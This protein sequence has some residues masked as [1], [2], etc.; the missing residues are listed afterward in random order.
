M[1]G[2]GSSTLLCT[3]DGVAVVVLSTPWDQ[4]DR[5]DMRRSPRAAISP[6]HACHSVSFGTWKKC[7]DDNA[8][9]HPH[10]SRL[11]SLK[12]QKWLDLGGPGPDLLTPDSLAS[13]CAEF[14][15]VVSEQQCTRT[16]P[17]RESFSQ[18][19]RKSHL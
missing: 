9:S 17:Q 18:V 10:K 6:M 16:R 7:R 19:T 8:A 1:I 12:V 14:D 13:K 11:G 15:S 3:D 5:P 4:R 2:H